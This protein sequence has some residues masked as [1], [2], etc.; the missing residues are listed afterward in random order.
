MPKIS[1]PRSVCC[2][3]CNRKQQDEGQGSTCSY[4]GC[5]PVPSYKYPKESSFH[6]DHLPESPPRTLEQYRRRRG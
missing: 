6:P 2:A 1:K 3:A 5:S 4:C